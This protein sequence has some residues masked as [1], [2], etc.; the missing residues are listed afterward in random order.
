M[1]TF[2]QQ[3]GKIRFSVAGSLFSDSLLESIDLP[4]IDNPHHTPNG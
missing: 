4:H 1:S 2:R 3:L